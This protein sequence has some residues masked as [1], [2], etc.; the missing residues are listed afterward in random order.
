MAGIKRTKP[1]TALVVEGG[2]MRG[3]FCAGVLDVF[4]E[5]L[6]DPFDL[7]IGV[8][9]G[10]CN[11]ASHLAEQHRRNYTIYMD[12]MTVPEFISMKKF[13]H[14]GHF[15]DLDYLWDVIDAKIP[16]A[17]DAI[18]KKR[19]KEFIITG[20]SVESGMPVYIH[21][22]PDICSLAL[23]ASSA[24]PLLYRKYIEVSGVALVDGGVADPIPAG[25][26]YRRG[27]RE[28]VVIRSRPAEYCKTKGFENI[29]SSFALRKHRNLSAA[30]ARQADTYQR[31]MDFILTPPRN[32]SIRQIAPGQQLLTGRTTQKKM[33]LI[34]DYELGRRLGE[35]FINGWRRS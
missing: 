8:S 31:N 22:T 27:A 6:F 5:N 4:Y 32:V 2:G 10:A 25:E 13:M 24:I 12:L 3:I 34:A 23:K 33:C 9:A 26:A 20:T 21:P 30:I 18:F 28:I 1:R 17:I 29:I 15:L 11:L 14:G 35:S 16:L 19:N 7:Y